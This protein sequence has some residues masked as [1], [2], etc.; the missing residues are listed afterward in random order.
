MQ[1]ASAAAKVA[2]FDV[3]FEFRAEPDG[4]GAVVGGQ[5][6]AK[7]LHH[8]VRVV[9]RFHEPIGFVPV[10]FPDVFEGLSRFAPQIVSTFGYGQRHGRQCC[11]CNDKVNRISFEKLMNTTLSD[12]S[13]VP[14]LELMNTR[15]LHRLP[16]VRLT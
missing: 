13:T 12:W 7:I 16:Q 2:L 4:I 11:V 5:H 6:V 15:V 9:V 14:S 10:L 1:L 8:N 3:G